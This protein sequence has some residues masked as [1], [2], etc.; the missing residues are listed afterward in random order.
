MWSGAASESRGG[1]YRLPCSLSPSQFEC[2]VE[3][4]T[5]ENILVNYTVR[6]RSLG[7]SQADASGSLASIAYHLEPARSMYMSRVTPLC[8]VLGLFSSVRRFVVDVG[9]ASVLAAMKRSV[10][11]TEAPL[12]GRTDVR[13]A[14]TPSRARNVTSRGQLSRRRIKSSHR[15]VGTLQHLFTTNHN[16]RTHSSS[17]V[18]FTNHHHVFQQQLQ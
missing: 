9:V 14:E 18:F 7:S 1:T 8:A 2:C 5:Q 12:A 6:S 3:C 11:A 4:S 16:Y 17:R 10:N 15:R 13:S